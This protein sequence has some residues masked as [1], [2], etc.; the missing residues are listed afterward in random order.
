M[1]QFQLPTMVAEQLVPVTRPGW[2][3]FVKQPAVP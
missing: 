2:A 1:A 3:L